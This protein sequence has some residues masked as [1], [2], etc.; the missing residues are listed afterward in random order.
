MH[1][2]KKENGILLLALGHPIYGNMA[3]TLAMSLKHHADCPPI[4]LVYH[5][6]ALNHLNDQKRS[7]FDTMSVC[8]DEAFMKKGKIAYFKA[9]TWM[10][11][12]SPF[13]NTLFLDADIIWFMYRSV[14]NLIQQLSQV[15]FTIQNREW[16]DL[17]NPE[18]E[19]VKWM[20]GRVADLRKQ[21]EK[22]KLW[23][24]HSELVWFKKCQK[25]KEYFDWVKE[26]FD[27]PPIPASDFAG[28]IADEFA[29]AIACLITGMEPHQSPFLPIYWHKLDHRQGTE[30]A[31]LKD[32]FYGYSVGGNNLRETE[33]EKYNL[34]ARG[35]AQRAGVQNPF[36][37]LPKKRVL[38]ERKSM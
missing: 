23:S 30:L 35:Y 4:H 31:R 26:L 34:L 17:S 33:I 8:P 5:G 20:W 27:N 38:A 1:E 12:L 2:L 32:K 13:D 6:S 22:G 29:F 19:K 37:L 16:W 14:N 25:N 18:S 10:Y 9:K 24:L 21:F 36:R 15:D 7:F 11:D 28:D 3:F